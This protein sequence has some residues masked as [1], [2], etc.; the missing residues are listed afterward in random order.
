MILGDLEIINF[1]NKG[2]IKPF[3]LENVN[4]NTY[5]LTLDAEIKLYVNETL[6]CRIDNP[7]IS[8]HIHNAMI[9]E[10]GKVYLAKTVEVIDLEPD[11]DSFICATLMGK[12]SL[13]RLGL[14][15]HISAGF[16]DTGFKGNIVLELRVEQPL[17]IYVG[18]PIAQIKFERSTVVDTPYNIKKSSK[19]NNQTEVIAS[20]MFENFK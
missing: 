8:T 1:G 14:D 20:K 16:I 5:D 9:L 13:G 12:S 17:I 18:M 3:N 2:K 4:P 11:F 7:T 6:D 19:Y 15:V 10:P